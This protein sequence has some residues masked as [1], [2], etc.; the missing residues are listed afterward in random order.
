MNDSEMILSWC[1][2]MREVVKHWDMY[3]NRKHRDYMRDYYKTR[4]G[5]DPE[6]R[7]RNLE[8]K[9]RSNNV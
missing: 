3:A 9:R 6:F 8:R 1:A 4:W 2:K 5:S 7:A